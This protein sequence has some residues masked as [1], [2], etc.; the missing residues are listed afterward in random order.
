MKFYSLN[1]LPIYVDD[2]FFKP[3]NKERTK[4]S[5]V[6]YNP[7]DAM[8][9]TPVLPRSRKTLE[10]HI[11][12]IQTNNLKRITV[13]A[14]DISFIKKCPSLEFIE[15]HPAIDA[16]DFDYSPLYE[17]P[18]IKELYAE[19]MYGL[20]AMYEGEKVMISTIDYS[21]IKGLKKVVL[22]GHLGHINI[23]LAEDLISLNMFNCP[24]FDNL[25][26]HIPYKSLE[27]LGICES[28]LRSLEG[29]QKASKL[30]KVDLSYN[31]RLTDISALGHLSDSLTY[32]EID[33]CGKIRDFSVFEKLNNLECLILKGNNTLD[34]LSFL[35]K[36]PKLKYLRLRM[37]VLDGDLSL[38]ENIPCVEI[39]N[40]KHYSHKN[41][42]LP[43]N[44]IDVESMFEI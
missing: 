39:K 15:I 14:N 33:S 6:V 22:S 42:D 29:I 24:H 34:D 19:T 44:H 5:L 7:S 35:K 26:G 41:E 8:I 38:C 36:M 13:A 16:I 37:N 30:R 9:V 43:K 31:R 23:H 32:L 2:F 18:N 40:R 17:M 3:Y 28:H 1:Q 20:G 25:S 27:H 12:L 21:K 4:D 10:E 11:E